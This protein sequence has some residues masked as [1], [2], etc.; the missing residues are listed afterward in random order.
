[1]DAH[2]II[3][4]GA[5][6]GGIEALREVVGSLP[7]DLPAA[8]FVALHISPH[9][10]S[11]LPAILTRAGKLPANHPVDREE[12]KRGRI[13]VAPP[14]HHLI[15]EDGHVAA[16]RGPRES[17][18]R[19]SADTLFRS[20]ADA[21]GQ[22][23]VGVVLT[24]ALDDGTAGLRAIKERGGLAVVQDPSDADHAGMPL[25]AMTGVKVDHCVPLKSL[26]PLLESLAR[27]PI[28]ASTGPSLPEVVTM[29]GNGRNT[30]FGF[31][32][33]ECHSS[34]QESYLGNLLQFSCRAGHTFTGEGLLAGQ[35]EALERSLWSSLIATEER[36]QLIS[37]LSRSMSF[38]NDGSY[39]AR[40]EKK[41]R[42]TTEHA[43]E[44]RQLLVGDDWYSIAD[45]HDVQERPLRSAPN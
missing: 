35:S 34:L 22:R 17:R 11:M 40:L 7:S 14:D 19:P 26:A 12:I 10:P 27:D 42:K 20:A 23:V 36:A 31:T 39:K 2:D 9:K 32:C 18:H 24:G 4:I 6:A 21:Y 13:Y 1:M 43:Q 15:I 25:S 8:L 29:S 33:P 3:V 38:E 37:R 16:R 30:E 41:A 44:L 28:A 5:S 45:L